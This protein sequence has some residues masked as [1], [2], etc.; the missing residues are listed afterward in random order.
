MS[1]ARGYAHKQEARA[2]LAESFIQRLRCVLA[3]YNRRPCDRRCSHV[4][5][6]QTDTNGYPEF[7]CTLNFWRSQQ[8]TPYHLLV[9]VG[10]S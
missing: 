1:F 3:V 10:S 8:A 6:L 5:H 4:R 2:P 9:A 7:K